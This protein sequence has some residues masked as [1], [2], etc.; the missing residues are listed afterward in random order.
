MY[1]INENK[2]TLIDHL[3]LVSTLVKSQGYDSLNI[4][5]KCQTT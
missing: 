4:K 2:P 1:E 3:S 5:K